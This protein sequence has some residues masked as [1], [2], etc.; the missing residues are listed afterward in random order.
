MLSIAK[1]LLRTTTRVL[2]HKKLK[3]LVIL[4]VAPSHCYS[5]VQTVPPRS[6]MAQ[7]AEQ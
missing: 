7:K 3:K 4:R 1:S 5:S 6:A 2:G